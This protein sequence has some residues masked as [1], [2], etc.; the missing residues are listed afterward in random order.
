M[1]IPRNI[2]HLRMLSADSSGWLRE[3]RATAER[4][5][6]LVCRRAF[7]RDCVDRTARGDDVWRWLTDCWGNWRWCTSACSRTTVQTQSPSPTD[8]SPFCVVCCFEP[9]QRWRRKSAQRIFSSTQNCRHYSI[10]RISQL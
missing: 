10:Q 8:G 4:D 7:Q 6:S 1:K 5:S 2:C 9:M 3:S